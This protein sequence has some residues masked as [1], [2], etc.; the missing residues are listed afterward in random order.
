M[1][2]SEDPRRR[3]FDCWNEEK[4]KL[5]SL[6]VKKPRFHERE[7]WWCS[8]GKNIGDEQDGKNITKP[9]LYYKAENYATD[10]KTEPLAELLIGPSGHLSLW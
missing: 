2:L 9:I 4:K 1:P 5:D 7:I 6:Q 8:L 10:L 3:T